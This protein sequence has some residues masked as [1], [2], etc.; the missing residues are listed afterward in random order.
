MRIVGFLSI[1]PIMPKSCSNSVGYIISL[2]LHSPI[3]KKQ[4]HT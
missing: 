1:N 4:S 2:E 3:K